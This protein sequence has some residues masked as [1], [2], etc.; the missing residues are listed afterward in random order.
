MAIYEFSVE[1]IYCNY[2]E[3]EADSLEE[4][5]ELAEEQANEYPSADEVRVEYIPRDEND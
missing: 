5:R 2:I 3:V 1:Y 4:A